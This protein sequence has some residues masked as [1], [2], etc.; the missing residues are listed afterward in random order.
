[1]AG[2]KRGALSEVVWPDRVIAV[3][4]GVTLATQEFAHNGD[5]RAMLVELHGE[6]V[7]SVLRT[8]TPTHKTAKPIQPQPPQHPA[9]QPQALGLWL[10]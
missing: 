2:E 4:K 9:N 3:Y 10:G 6:E 1:M 5:I 8:P 7:C